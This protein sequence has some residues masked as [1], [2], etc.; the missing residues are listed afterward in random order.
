MLLKTARTARINCRRP[1]LPLT[2]RAHSAE[3]AG[4]TCTRDHYGVATDGPRRPVKSAPTTSTTRA[5]ALPE[6]ACPP[7][8]TAATTTAI[9]WPGSLPSKGNPPHGPSQVLEK[10]RPLKGAVTDQWS[11][12]PLIE[13]GRH[14]CPQI[15]KITDQQL[16]GR[17]DHDPTCPADVTKTGP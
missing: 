7:R 1:R 13:S 15:Q 4:C 8:T 11:Q 6:K 10:I 16:E 14:R 12:V 5:D 2:D 9:K 3:R 17:L